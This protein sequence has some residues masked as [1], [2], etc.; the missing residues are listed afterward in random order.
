MIRLNCVFSNE[1]RKTLTKQLVTFQI[2]NHSF[3][4]LVVHNLVLNQI[5]LLFG[6]LCTAFL[7]FEVRTKF[8][9]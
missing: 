9:K 7:R 2:T 3:I 5:L 1:F 4:I 8:I 6:M